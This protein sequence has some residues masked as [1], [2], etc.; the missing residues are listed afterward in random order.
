MPGTILI[1]GGSG[2]IGNAIINT[3]H[4]A[5]YRHICNIDKERPTKEAVESEYFEVDLLDT[6]K[7]ESTV[8]H[9]LSRHT[10]YG[11]IHCAGWGGPF[12][13]ITQVSQK[14][15]N[16]ILQ[17]NLS[18]AFICIKDI[19]SQMAENRFG[20]IVVIA[21]ALSVV[22]ARHSVAYS[23]SK[24]ALVGMVKSLCDEWGEYGIT[25]NLVSPGYVNTRMGVQE[26]QVE[27]HLA[28]VLGITPVKKIAEP[29]EIARVVEFLLS[30]ESG[31]INGANWTVD[32]GI[33]AI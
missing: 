6:E 18:S 14:E 12:H 24:H 5:G 3:L 33:T 26:E 13:N 11:F 27:S 2:G 4:R 19:I 30:K 15:W 7:L 29:S 31:Y 28:K 23:A 17:I 9:I 22:G 8:R 21:S 16:S 10:M 1:T 32:G 25:A 20:R